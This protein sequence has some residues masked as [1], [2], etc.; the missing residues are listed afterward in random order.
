MTTDQ[1]RRVGVMTQPVSSYNS[2]AAP[3]TYEQVSLEKKICAF[4]KI[5]A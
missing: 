2:V 1:V 5:L 3:V 4:F